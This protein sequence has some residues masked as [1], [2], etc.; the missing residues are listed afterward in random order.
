MKLRLK[1]RISFFGKRDASPFFKLGA[2]QF[3][4]LASKKIKNISTRAV[5][6]FLS[7]G[8]LTGSIAAANVIYTP[9]YSVN[10]NGNE[11]GIVLNEDSFRQAVN[12]AEAEATAALGAES[13]IEENASASF[14]LA[15]K[16]DV[17]TPD[18]LTTAM[19]EQVDELER[20]FILNINGEAV[21]YLNSEAEMSTLLEQ[22][23]KPFKTE[24]TIRTEFQQ[25]VS[26]DDGYASL[27]LLSNFDDIYALLTSHTKEAVTYTVV[28]GDS[29]WEIAR[30][31]DMSISELLSMNPHVT[32][33]HLNIGEVL[34]VEEAV[35]FLSVITVDKSVYEE[36]IASPITY[37]DDSSMY[38]GETKTKTEGADG[39][40]QVQAEVTYQNGIE[41]KREV[42][43]T[44]TLQE[45]TETII[46][47]GT[48][49]R[50]KTASTGN[51]IWPVKGTITS[52]TGTRTLLGSTGYHSGLDIGVPYGTKVKAADGGT[53]TFAGWKGNY[54]NLVIITHDNGNQTY[55][56]HNSE[57]LVSKGDKVYQGQAI[58]KAG[59]TGR[60]TGS[61]CHFEVRV[62]GKTQNPYDYLP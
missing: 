4:M 47:R 22:I 39:L 15:R 14:T 13:V 24:N 53:V 16:T 49:E 54:G 52:S 19:L 26:V 59:S 17:I 44:T 18:E 11:L 37:V 31:Y 62:N 28:K 57:L 3:V 51:Y 32:E 1:D 42:I 50:P 33:D 58:A 21:G 48:K 36:V 30:N 56:A 6:I 5:G 60:S 34:T 46:L 10:Y 61:H 35:P 41:I 29:Y 9:A 20:G 27:E 2:M 38:Q 23:A 45:A 43:E 7:A 8:C 40:A 25:T 55:Y 12:A